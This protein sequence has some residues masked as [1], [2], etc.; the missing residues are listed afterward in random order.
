LNGFGHYDYVREISPKNSI[1]FGQY[2]KI[3]PK[4]MENDGS[5]YKK[6]QKPIFKKLV[7]TA[8]LVV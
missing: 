3:S 6:T 4:Y 2:G 7:I 1:F 8:L 5:K